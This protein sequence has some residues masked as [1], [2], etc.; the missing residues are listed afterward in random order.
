M[1]SKTIAVKAKP[2]RTP[3]IVEKS[4]PSVPTFTPA[5]NVFGA[6]CISASFFKQPSPGP[7]TP[8]CCGQIRQY[9][10]ISYKTLQYSRGLE[11]VRSEWKAGGGWRAP[12]PSAPLL[13]N[14][15][16]I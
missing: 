1:S 10:A 8:H 16:D 15:R 12:G 13:S 14:G 3:V 11:G 4:V 9:I 2:A 5:G 6:Q 7:R